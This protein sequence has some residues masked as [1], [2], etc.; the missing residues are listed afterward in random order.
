MSR[1]IALVGCGAIAN[2]FYLQA[3]I[4]RR[5]D[6]DRIW[7]VDPRDS[8]LA[9]ACAITGSEKAHVLSEISDELQYVIIA[10]PNGTHFSLAQEALSRGAHVLI[11]KPFVIFPEDG[12]K[13]SNIAAARNLIIAV[14]QTRRLFPYTRELRRRIKIGEFGNLQSIVHNEGGKFDWPL[15][16]GAIFA[17]DAQRTGVIM[18]M[19]VHVVDF[20]QVLCEPK[21]S[22]VAAVHDGFRGPEGL[23]E[24]KLTA[25]E[26]PVVISAQSVSDAEK[27]CMPVI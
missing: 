3:L 21:W 7:L 4:K 2:R 22:F 9:N 12:R 26:V 5:R 8:A 17:H 1:N 15:Q 13:L 27:R 14:N 20:Y 6:F 16:S 24:I 19:G 18:D 25:N 23:A 10:A 11:E